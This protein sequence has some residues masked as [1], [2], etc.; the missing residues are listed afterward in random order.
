M[1]SISHSR[2]HRIFYYIPLCV[3][4]FCFILTTFQSHGY[5]MGIWNIIII[6]VV[7]T[8]YDCMV[9]V[10][11]LVFIFPNTWW[12]VRIKFAKP[13]MEYSLSNHSQIRQSFQHLREPTC[14]LLHSFIHFMDVVA[15]YLC[16]IK[17]IRLRFSHSCFECYTIEHFL[18]IA[19]QS[20]HVLKQK[21]RTKEVCSAANPISV[22]HHNGFVSW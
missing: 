13:E 16:H 6:W 4:G 17:H 2:S 19:L 8:S 9:L 10:L 15:L 18:A 20:I 22:N 3:C 12:F 5:R 7:W 21:T 1:V 11:V 14:V